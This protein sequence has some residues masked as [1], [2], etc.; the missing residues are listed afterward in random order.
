VVTVEYRMYHKNCSDIGITTGT[1]YDGFKRFQTDVGHYTI[2]ANTPG[3][4]VPV[5]TD[6][7]S[8]NLPN[9]V[10]AGMDIYVVWR[11]AGGAV[12]GSTYVD[13]NGRDDY[14]CATTLCGVGWNA[15]YGAW[16]Y[17]NS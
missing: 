9:G 14:K 11:S 7:I 13:Y 5:W 4:T 12:L 15:K 3:T 2:A 6:F 16:I 10:M 8:A 17:L 1:C